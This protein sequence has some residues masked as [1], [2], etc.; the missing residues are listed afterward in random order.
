MKA[1]LYF[2]LLAW[3]SSSCSKFQYISVQT[4][5]EKDKRGGIFIENDSMAFYYKFSGAAGPASV[6]IYN[7]LESPIE[8]H[9]N[10]S[11][12]IIREKELR[13]LSKEGI[14]K[15]PVSKVHHWEAKVQSPSYENSR[16]EL[17]VSTITP[18]AF[19]ESAPLHLKNRFFKLDYRFVKN[20]DV[21]GHTV[22]AQSFNQDNTPF[23]F[24]S[25]L[26]LS[27]GVKPG[28]KYVLEHLF[29]V[30][31]ILQTTVPANHFDPYK[32]RDDKFYISKPSGFGVFV[33]ATAIF[34][35]V[36]AITSSRF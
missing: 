26:V 13:I 33:A 35:Y 21:N 22:R 2:L 31:E 3:I 29:W 18:G 4:S 36:L 10:Q 5:E 24:R 12:V 8:V 25:T 27:V 20:L 32:G 17:V 16:K 15:Q 11:T 30:E 6:R 1:V 23:E 9:W 14:E 19:I 7:K 28:R 34:G